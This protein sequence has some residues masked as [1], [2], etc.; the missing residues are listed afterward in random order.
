M[1]GKRALR[2]LHVIRPVCGTIDTSCKSA[3][4]S[5]LSPHPWQVCIISCHH[6][7]ASFAQSVLLC[8]Q[9]LS[10]ALCLCVSGKGIVGW[11]S[12]SEAPARKSPAKAFSP[13]GTASARDVKVVLGNKQMM[14]DEGI[15]I[16]KGVDDYMRDMEVSEAQDDSS[17]F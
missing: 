11:A 14:A 4:S 10:P 16:S 3:M 2:K 1:S 9:K 15:A 12:S 7:I 5:L 6:L 17:I 8:L 13:N